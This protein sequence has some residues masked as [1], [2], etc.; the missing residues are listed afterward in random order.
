LK[1]GTRKKD[2]K[3]KKYGKKKVKEKLSSESIVE[4][5]RT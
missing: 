1:G 5:R 2:F 4:G 3:K